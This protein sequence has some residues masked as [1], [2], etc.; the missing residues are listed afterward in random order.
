[1]PQ[2]ADG[3][4]AAPAARG[5]GRRQPAESKA[6]PRSNVARVASNGKLL[7]D[8]FYRGTAFGI[9]LRP[10]APAMLTG[11]LRLA[12]LPLRKDAP[13]LLAKEARPEFGD[14]QSVVSVDDARIDPR[15]QVYLKAP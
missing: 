10:S 11:E 1:M 7:T 3:F 15:C 6:T 12:I 13:V 2:P 5:T 4:C 8:D 14:R 9:G